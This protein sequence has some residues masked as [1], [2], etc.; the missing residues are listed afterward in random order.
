MGFWKKLFT[1]GLI[2]DKEETNQKLKIKQP[3]QNKLEKISIGT[4]KSQEHCVIFS[5]NI[6]EGWRAD[7]VIVAEIEGD[8][9]FPYG[10]E[11]TF[12]RRQNL[13]INNELI[14]DVKS[15]YRSKTSEYTFFKD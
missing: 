13:Y 11:Y 15:V 9:P 12:K 8:N 10:Q 14:G 6:Q 4:P 2:D 1:L 5:R 3:K 7:T